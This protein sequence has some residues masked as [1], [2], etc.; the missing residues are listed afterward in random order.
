MRQ[1]RLKMSIEATWSISLD[2]DCPNCKEYVDLLTHP[3]FW[4]GRK[5]EIGETETARTVCAEVVCPECGH[6]FTVDFTY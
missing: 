4:D 6:E 5:I 2:C 1:K 3:D